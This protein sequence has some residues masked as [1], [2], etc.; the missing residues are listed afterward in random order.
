MTAAERERAEDIFYRA[1]AVGDSA[2]RQ[3]FLEGAY[4]GDQAMRVAVE[5][6]LAAHAAAEGFFQASGSAIAPAAA[7]LRALASDPKLGANGGTEAS[8][9]EADGR[10]VGPYKLLQKIG[11]GG[12]G[13]VYLAEQEQPVRRLVA[14]KIIKLGMD[15]RNVI[16]RFKAELQALALMEHPNIA[17]VLDAGATATGRPYFVMELVRGIKLTDYCDESRLDVRARLELFIQICHA[18]QHAHQKGVIHRDLKP[19][20]ILVTLHDGVPVPKVID[21]GI[22]KATAGRLTDNTLFTAFDQFVGT[23]AYMSPEQAEMSGL[24]VDTRSD[25]Y[26]LGVLLYELL[27]GRTPFDQQQLIGS[28]LD[29][30]R[31]T[32]R[33]TE[34]DPPSTL[35]T[36]R[37]G[38]S[39]TTAKRRHTDA[40]RLITLVRGD[41]DW[42]VMKALEKDRRRRYETAN[43]LA[44]DVQRYLDNE[45]VLAR[46]PSRIYRWQKLVQRHRAVF[47][48][49]A[50]VAAALVMGLGTSTW[51]FFRERE[52][53]LEQVRLRQAAENRQKLT[54]ATVLLSKEH[55]AEADRLVSGIPDS[56]ATLEYAAVYRIL[57]GWNA[58][59]ERWAEAS[60]R[61]A[62]LFRM[63][64]PDKAE[65][66]LD[67]LRYGPVLVMGGDSPAY[68]ALR[69][70]AVERYAH[71]TDPVWAERV[72]KVSLLTPAN[73]ELLR[74]LQPLA[75]LAEKSLDPNATGP[76][77]GMAE[78]RGFSLS[79]M[80]YRQGD[81]AGAEAMCRR[82][83]AYHFPNEVLTASLELVLAMSHSRLGQAEAARTELA[84]SRPVIESNAA[85]NFSWYWFDW[86]F[87]R[88]LLIEARALI[89]R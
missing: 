16:A 72:V 69:R 78:W 62:T 8:L 13:V 74:A 64:A 14:L 6:M 70:S 15:T 20:N 82:A 39:T 4:A 63:G 58:G 48:S 77:C 32:L 42:I 27:A 46:P 9:D 76:E 85:V 5:D 38:G 28:G 56:E 34:P 86:L 57:G 30:M 73:P 80:K 18:V 50:V 35:L 81:F 24:D 40:K 21:F 36:L 65:A 19:S 49:G 68:E 7:A 51:L 75:E 71:T 66:S 29:A 17:Q 3:A 45:E 54:E 23:P 79:L 43:A 60:A 41:L 89:K 67:Y 26:S 33:E 37:R 31:R 2:A 1:L 47:L 61:F 44:L 84:R 11:E 25:I 55:F 87:A 53:R 22:A 10:L 12:C 88:V 52:A 83:L 59:Q